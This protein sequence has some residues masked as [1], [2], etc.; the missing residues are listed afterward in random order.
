VEQLAV[1]ASSHLIWKGQQ[2]KRETIEINLI[3]FLG[4]R[5]L[6]FLK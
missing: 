3:F 6:K 1:G 2:V 4:E 5:E